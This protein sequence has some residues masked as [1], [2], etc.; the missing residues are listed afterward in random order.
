MGAKDTLILV[1]TI[2]SISA[3]LVIFIASV[4]GALQPRPSIPA[5]AREDDV[6]PTYVNDTAT[7][8]LREGQK[9]G[10]IIVTFIKPNG[11]VVFD[12]I[13]DVETPVVLSTGEATR[14]CDYHMVL[15]NV[16]TDTVTF[17]ITR[18][19]YCFEGGYPYCWHMYNPKI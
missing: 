14:T 11:R 9:S 13:S 16:T 2:G 7:V 3:I 10:P 5:W 4:T 19:D 17:E 15:L 12:T 1:A 8:T 6:T 18:G